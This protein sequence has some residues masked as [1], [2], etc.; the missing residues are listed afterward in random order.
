[1]TTTHY[2]TAAEQARQA[3][4]I[5]S[6]VQVALGYDTAQFLLGVP[7]DRSVRSSTT[8][9]GCPAF[10]KD[11]DAIGNLENFLEPVRDEDERLSS[12]DQTVAPARSNRKRWGRCRRASG[13]FGGARFNS[14]PA[15]GGRSHAPALPGGRPSLRVIG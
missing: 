12:L 7:L 9:E 5:E 4:D 3:N 13:I 10:T 1:M 8:R 11:G 2:L 15:S 14:G 6:F